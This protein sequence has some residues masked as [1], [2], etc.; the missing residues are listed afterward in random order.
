[1]HVFPCFQILPHRQKWKT[2]RIQHISRMTWSIKIKNKKME[3][4]RV[5]TLSLNSWHKILKWQINMFKE[6]G[7]HSHREHIL[8]V[9]LQRKTSGNNRAAFFKTLMKQW[10][11]YFIY[12]R[13]PRHSSWHCLWRGRTSEGWCFVLTTV[14]ILVFASRTPL[15]KKQCPVRVVI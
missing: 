10:Q 12:Y 11:H 3:Q 15:L 14:T 8:K 9:L 7:E 5:T 13:M 6:K 1:M 2:T 4:G